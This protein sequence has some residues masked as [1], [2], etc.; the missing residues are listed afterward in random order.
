MDVNPGGR[1]KPVTARTF[2]TAASSS[3]EL[4]APSK[5]SRTMPRRSTTNVNGSLCRCHSFTHW[6]VPFAG[7]LSL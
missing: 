6:F 2:F 4:K 5:R 3:A 7:S 1:L